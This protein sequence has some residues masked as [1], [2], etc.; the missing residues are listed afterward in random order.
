MMA[1]RQWYLTKL[2]GSLLGL[3]LFISTCVGA[4]NIIFDLKRDVRGN[5]ADIV[6]HK[7]TDAGKWN[8][9]EIDID[10]LEDG[11][12]ALQLAGA[13]SE[14]HYQA[15]LADM[16]NLKSQNLKILEILS[17]FEVTE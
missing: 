17:Q 4:A 15:I 1:D 2:V 10:E 11:Q 14:A 16:A 12:H 3:M 5:T 9:V 13:V 7:A 8:R 6:E